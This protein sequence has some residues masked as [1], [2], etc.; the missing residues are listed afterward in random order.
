MKKNI[1]ILTVIMMMAAS[2][3]FAGCAD[4]DITE[5]DAN[6]EYGE[7]DDTSSDEEYAEDED[8]S[9][10]D[11]ETAEAEDEED[12]TEPAEEETNESEDDEYPADEGGSILCFDTTTF[13]GTNVNTKDIFSGNKITLVNVWASWCGPCVMEI[14]EL[15]KMSGQLREKDCGMVGLLID[16]EDPNGLADAKDIL[17]DASAQYTNL[18]FP[19]AVSNELNL[20][21]V[22]TTFFVDSKG[23]ILGEPVIGARPQIYL[24]TIDSLLASM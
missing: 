8:W 3:V 7:E 6:I 5:E 15:E 13:D 17:S 11:T 18:V 19:S 23:N 24:E 22:P 2:L 10:Y 21:S 9:D 16:G 4:E 20:Q 1:R 12:D 14:P